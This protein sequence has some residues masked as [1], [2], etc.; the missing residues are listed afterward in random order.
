MGVR[1]VR[2]DMSTDHREPMG[3]RHMTVV[4]ENFEAEDGEVDAEESG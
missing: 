3:L 4:P 1:P 2:M